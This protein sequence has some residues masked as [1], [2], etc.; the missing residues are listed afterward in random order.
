MLIDPLPGKVQQLIRGYEDELRE[1][2]W[3]HCSPFDKALH[4]VSR[5]RIDERYRGD[6]VEARGKTEGAIREY[7]AAHPAEVKPDYFSVLVE[8][9]LNQAE[10]RVQA[11]YDAQVRRVV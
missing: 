6:A 11:W 9:C 5:K 7:F 8:P 10:R 4:P 2:L 3:E 1:L